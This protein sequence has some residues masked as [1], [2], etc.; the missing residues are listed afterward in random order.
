MNSQSRSFQGLIFDMDGVLS[1]TM[2]YHL[3]AWEIYLGQTPELANARQD[4][5]WEM[6]GRRNSELLPEVLSRPVSDAEVKRWGD[7][8]EA[9][10]RDLIRGQIVWLPGLILFLKAAQG[11]GLKLG[12]GTSAC[13]ENTDLILSHQ[14]LGDFF[15]ARVIETDVVRG[16][17]DPQCY[18]LVAERLGLAPEQCLVFEDAVVGVKAA[19]AAGM[20]CWGVLT[21]H[22]AA[23][24]EAVGAE[25]CIADFSD[26][27]LLALLPD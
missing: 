17:P 19:I 26:R 12:L 23:E 25:V 11:A 18:L 3:K 2:P 6:G 10:Y 4:R 20:R 21:T 1:D 15:A 9:I 5:L 7:G 22:S 14:N 27:R 13:R 24:L 8:K 16:K